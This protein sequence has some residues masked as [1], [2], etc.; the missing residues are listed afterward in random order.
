MDGALVW[1]R[2]NGESWEAEKHQS[3][4]VPHAGSR[5]TPTVDGETVFHLSD[6]GSLT[7]FDVADG[8][9]RWRV[10]VMER[11]G[12]EKSEYGYSESVLVLGNRLFC[13]PGGKKAGAAAL[14]KRTGATIWVNTDVA[15]P[16]G[17]A[18]FVR[19]EIAGVEQIISL[20]ASRVFA[21]SPKDGRLLWQYPFANKRD[22]NVSDVVVSGNRVYASS[23]YGRGSVLLE[24]RR[25]PEGRLSVE[26]V[27]STELLDNHH[28]GVV[29]HDGF[30]YG[31]GHEARGWF[32][33]KLASGEQAWRT[34]GKGSLT[35]ADGHLYTLDERGELNLV[36]ATSD[37][38]VSVGSFQAPRGGRA[39]H[40]AHPVVCGG[41]LYV[42]HSDQLFAY[43]VRAR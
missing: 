19:A 1:R 4:A 15:D 26:L 14:D 2:P 10:N 18:S 7:A 22:N 37:E 35:Y 32:C 30:L 5:G 28:G 3:W 43:D 31:A 23:G 42:R 11:F 17:Y 16:I 41:R 25:G 39:L 38:Y 6:M 36:R 34:D 33:L 9:E 24:P 13:S 40:W 12:A 20:T 8:R 27:W 29:L 21:L